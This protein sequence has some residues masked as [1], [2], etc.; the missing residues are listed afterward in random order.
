MSTMQKIAEIEA[1]MA[2]TQKNK[3][4]SGHLGLLKVGHA[5][6]NRGSSHGPPRSVCDRAGGMATSGFTT[7]DLTILFAAALGGWKP[8]RRNWRSCE[9][10]SWT[11]R[12]GRRVAVARASTSPKQAWLVWVSLAFL[13]CVTHPSWDGPPHAHARPTGFVWGCIQAPLPVDAVDDCRLQLTG[14]FSEVAA[15][16]FTT[17]TCVP[18]VIRYKGAKIQLLDLPGG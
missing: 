17:L 16:E 8:N 6:L 10:S 1:E 14:T 15:Y 4:T 13:R 18:G 3:A 11:R 7:H 9:G 2:R 5:H 12:V